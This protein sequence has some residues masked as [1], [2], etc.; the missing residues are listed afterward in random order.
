M[1]PVSSGA[2]GRVALVSSVVVRARY[3]RN[4]AAAGRQFAARF[5]AS[6]TGIGGALATRSATA[7]SVS[8]HHLRAVAFAEPLGVPLVR[9]PCLGRR[10]CI[11][12]ALAIGALRAARR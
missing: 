3:A 5:S 11:M 4:L 10:A 8:V 9:S 1:A 2:R 12:Y 7:A 6:R